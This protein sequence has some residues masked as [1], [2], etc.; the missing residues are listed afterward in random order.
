MRRRVWTF[1]HCVWLLALAA[2]AEDARQ[3][4]VHVEIRDE[5]TGSDLK[6]S[7]SRKAAVGTKGV[8]F[9]E[10]VV[11]VESRRYP[12]VGVFVTS[13][14][15]VEAPKG[16]FWAL[17][18]NGERAQKGISDLTINEPIRIR[19]DLVELEEP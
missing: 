14:C 4:A 7:I 8:D 2:A 11:E 3:V 10:E 9:M 15:G 18:I 5:L 1:V 17:S 6:V 16:T 19:W 13:L 12:G